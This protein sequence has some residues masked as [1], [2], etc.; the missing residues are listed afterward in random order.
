MEDVTRG[1]LVWSDSAGVRQMLRVKP[2]TDTLALLAT[3]YRAE[4]E[5]RRAA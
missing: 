5:K 2:V 1:R 4:T 3:A